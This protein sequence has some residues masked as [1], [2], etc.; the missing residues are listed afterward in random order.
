MTRREMVLLVLVHQAGMVRG[1]DTVYTCF[2]RVLAQIK[3][4][5]VLSWFMCPDIVL[6][7]NAEG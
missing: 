3:M 7:K 4:E 6:P 2:G 5:V 1:N